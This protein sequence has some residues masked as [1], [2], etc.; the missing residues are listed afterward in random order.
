MKV[1]HLLPK[2]TILSVYTCLIIL[3]ITSC[4]KEEFIPGQFEIDDISGPKL[5][6]SGSNSLLYF[7]SETFMIVS[8]QPL[9][10]T[11]T[12]DNPD[13]GYFDNFIIR[14]QNGNGG[15]SKVTRMEIL[16]DG[17]RIISFSDFRRNARVISKKLN[18][19]K[20][21]SVL[22]VRLD[23]SPGRF[24]KVMIECSLSETTVADVEGNYYRT[25]RIGNQWWLAENLKTTRF[26]DGAP[27]PNVTGN[28]EWYDFT[29]DHKS[30]YCW[31]DNNLTN[32][33]TY[34]ALYNWT[35]A[36]DAR[37][38][39]DG[40]HVPESNDVFEL[41]SFLDNDANIGVYSFIAGGLL[42]EEGTENWSDP[43]A[44]ASNETGFTALPGGYRFLD[45]S[46]TGMGTNGTWWTDAGISYFHMNYDNSYLIF[47]EGRDEYG[48]S[49][50]C[51]KD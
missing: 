15:S 6:L 34:G 35:A 33:N 14:V 11:R 36:G 32:K 50:R 27:I 20:N 29:V 23:G 24:I 47:G 38:C 39:P 5:A 26:N 49:V 43:N 44:D 7:P 16:L 46:F 8:R 25:I 37:L 10:E 1:L 12:L 13:F 31:Y 3:T 28:T 51:I 18:G 2:Q 19:L 17:E 48:H 9:N 4:Q 21:G 22:E 30:G 41:A 40:W 42:K 45:G